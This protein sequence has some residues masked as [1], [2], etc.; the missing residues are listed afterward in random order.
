M[1]SLE[2]T[3]SLV[4]ATECDLFGLAAAELDNE[5]SS[6]SGVTVHEPDDLVGA[7]LTTGQQNPPQWLG[8][9]A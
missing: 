9:L 8:G 2:P 4:L 3:Q 1:R 5:P 6:V 7:S